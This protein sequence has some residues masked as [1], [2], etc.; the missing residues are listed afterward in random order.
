MDLNIVKFIQK[1]NCGFLDGVNTIIT[2]LGETSMFFML[3]VA[4]YLCYRKEFAVKFYFFFI[5]S[6]ITNSLFKGAFKRARP[7]TYDGVIDVRHTT[8]YSFPSGHSQNY[9]LQASLIGCEYFKNNKNKKYR[10]ILGV[11]L[12]VVGLLV[13]LSR[14]Y[15]GQHFLSDVLVGLLLGTLFGI[16]LE[17]LFRLIPAK[18]KNKCTTKRV[19]IGCVPVVLVLLM[20]VEG[21]N[22]ISGHTL[23]V[24]YTYLAIYLA[25]MIGYSIDCIYIKYSEHAVWYIQLFKIFLAGLGIVGLSFAFSWI[26]IEL[27]KNFVFYFTSTLYVTLGLPTLFKFLLKEKQQTKEVKENEVV[28]TNDVEEVVANNTENTQEQIEK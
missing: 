25:L 14:V 12:G 1:A 2:I 17:L 10:I 28:S 5:L 3:F 26:K 16:G 11:C 18:I 15:L 22:I 9:A 13:G 7:Y 6:G 27:V 23:D 8:G 4:I 19:L 21:F 24:F 20:L